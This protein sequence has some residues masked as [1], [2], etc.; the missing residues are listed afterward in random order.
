MPRGR[1]QGDQRAEATILPVSSS[2]PLE[3]PWFRLLELARL[4]QPW[5]AHV[6]GAVFSPKQPQVTVTGFIIQETGRHPVLCNQAA[7]CKSLQMGH[8]T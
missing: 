4:E 1:C 3:H 6:A 7:S 5:Q 8:S 2:Y